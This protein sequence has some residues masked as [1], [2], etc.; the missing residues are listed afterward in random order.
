MCSFWLDG[1]CLGPMDDRFC[2]LDREGLIRLIA[3]LEGTNAAQAVRIEQLQARVCE[4]EAKLKGPGQGTQVP[5]FIKP[6]RRKRG[7]PR[8]RKRRAQAFV[9]RREEPTRQVE[10]AQAFQDKGGEGDLGLGC[11]ECLGARPA[12]AMTCS[13][14]KMAKEFWVK[15]MTGAM[16]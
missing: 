2:E 7:A 16:P 8:P 3:Q 11:S 13:M 5:E 9:R 10:H 12:M 14:S 15:T 1:L 4:L 6:S